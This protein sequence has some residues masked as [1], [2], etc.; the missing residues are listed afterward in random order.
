[1]GPSRRCRLP[2]SSRPPLLTGA[3]RSSAAAAIL[4][5]L[6]V[7]GVAALAGL[8]SSQ[9]QSLIPFDEALYASRARLMLATGDWLDPFAEP[10]HKTPG[11]YWLIALS[12]QLLGV[13]EGAARLPSALAAVLAAL[14]T[15][16]LGRR[17]LGARAGLLAA[18][19]LPTM[20]LWFHAGRYASPDLPFLCLVLIAQLALVHSNEAGRSVGWGQRG[21]WMLAGVALGLALMVRSLMLSLPLLALLPY[22]LLSVRRQG[23]RVLPWLGAGLALGLLPLLLWLHLMLQRH[24]PEALTALLGFAGQKSSRGLLRGA[25]FYPLNLLVNTAPA[26]LIG[27]L[28]IPRLRRLPAREQSL[29]LGY[30]LILLGLLLLISSRFAHYA[31]PLYPALALLCG[32][33]LDA[34]WAGLSPPPA[35]AWRGVGLLVG[36]AGVVVIGLAL[37]LALASGLR[38]PAG[39]PSVAPSTLRAIGL[40]GGAGLA[41]AGALW[42]RSPPGGTGWRLGL[43]LVATS[44]LGC[45]LA[46]VAAG[47]LG[48]ASAPLKAFLQQPQVA[49]VV[50]REP[51]WL[52]GLKQAGGSRSQRT[53]RS[54]L[55]SLLRFYLPQP[56]LLEAPR[57]GDAAPSAL[58]A[59]AAVILPASLWSE[60][61]PQYPRGRIIG[62]FNDLLLVRL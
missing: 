60:L 53:Q 42:L 31:L 12:L 37:A 4:L 57:P 59:G 28:A 32:A 56:Q 7:A 9:H 27:L 41:A 23:L 19:A 5:V 3:R 24:G 52:V 6:A 16:A 34:G 49:A 22:G 14:L 46:L 33:A 17:L 10:H 61:Q 2:A 18:L 29:L 51:V 25:G 55:Q 48:N 13:H 20:P 43:A 38:P 8:W 21:A 58:A 35:R 26:G 54:K 39:L 44:Q 47:V 62:R 45:L 50:Q 30:P 36:F 15:L 40:I 1:M 11:S